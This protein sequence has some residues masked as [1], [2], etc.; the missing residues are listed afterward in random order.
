[1]LASAMTVQRHKVC[2]IPEAIANLMRRNGVRDRAELANVLRISR[3]H[4]YSVF[5]S[6]CSGTA[7]T[8]LAQLARLFPTGV[9]EARAAAR[10]AVQ[11]T[12]AAARLFQHGR[13]GHKLGLRPRCIGG[14]RRSS[15]FAGS[16]RRRLCGRAGGGARDL[17]FQPAPGHGVRPSHPLRPGPPVEPRNR[18]RN[19]IV[20]EV[21]LITPGSR[22]APTSTSPSGITAPNRSRRNNSSEKLTVDNFRLDG[23]RLPSKGDQRW[24]C[25]FGNSWACWP[26]RDIG[27]RRDGRSGPGAAVGCGSGGRPWGGGG[28]CDSDYRPDGSYMHCEAVYVMGFGGNCY[29]VSPDPRREQIRGAVVISVAIAPA[30]VLTGCS[31]HDAVPVPGAPHASTHLRRGPARQNPLRRPDHHLRQ[32]VL[33]STYR[34]VIHEECTQ[35]RRPGAGR[36]RMMLAPG[37]L[38]GAQPDFDVYPTTEAEVALATTKVPVTTR[39]SWGPPTKSPAYDNGSPPFDSGPPYDEPTYEAPRAHLR[40]PSSRRY[41]E[42]TYDAPEPTYEAPESHL[43]GP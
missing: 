36:D 11:A 2:W 1:M 4:A 9:G 22:P 26:W 5:N 43:R 6:D 33:P 12:F 19:T 35:G 40:G 42:P 25:V 23:T 28:Y 16:Q 8:L 32:L 13:G 31:S 34:K 41:D 21:S 15:G 18:H 10:A 39:R 38:A 20:A 7:P 3:S 30:L 27:G 29:R 17:R 14:A 24:F 37:P